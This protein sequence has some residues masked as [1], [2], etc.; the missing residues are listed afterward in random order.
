MANKGNT[1]FEV[2]N[3]EGIGWVE[4]PA[5]PGFWIWDKTAV[6]EAP[7]DGKQYC[8]QNADWTEAVTQSHNHEIGD[9]DG[10]EDQLNDIKLEVDQ[11]SGQLVFGGT[12]DATNDQVVRGL[13]PGLS[14]LTPLPSDGVIEDTFLIVVVPGTWKKDGSQLN[15]GDW[16]VANRDG[17]WDCIQYTSTG[18]GTAVADWNTITNKPDFDAIYAQLVHSHVISDV[19][20][21][22]AELDG[23]AA[24]IV[25]K[26][27]GFY[28]NTAFNKNF[29]TTAGTVAEGDHNHDADYLQVETD[30]VFTASVAGGITQTDIDNWN[31]GGTAAGADN[32]QYWRYQ[33]DGTS[34]TNIMTMHTVNF[35][36][37]DNM[38]ISKDG[39]G[40]IVFKSTAT[41][42]GSGTDSRITDT[43][44]S[45]WDSAFN[46]GDHS[47][48]GY[49]D[50]S[51]L[52]NYATT[53]WVTSSFQPLGSYITSETD[54]VFTASPAYGITSK[55]ITDWD[56]AAAG[57]G[58]GSGSD[59][60]RISNTDI[61][62]WHEAYGWGDHSTYS[63]AT[64]TW[65]NNKN[66]ATQTWVN[67]KSYATQ[68]WVTSQ[69]YA[70]QSWVTT[71]GYLT[72]GSLTGYATQT[73][74]NNQGFA[75]GSFVPTS[76]NSTISG[77]L[78]ATDFVAS[79]DERLKKNVCTA[80]TGVLE[81]IR[82]V[83][84]EWKESGQ[85][86]SGVIAQELEAVPELAHLVHTGED[87]GTKHVSYLG[88]IGYLIE[89]VKSLR[90][91]IEELK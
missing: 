43:Q 11:L 54:P 78:T 90:A 70:T 49:L 7:E 12:Y 82:G 3:P 79:S 72:S 40:A 38:D 69:S 48:Q 37:G 59:D 33:I 58:G 22:Q 25:A 35:K 71:Q 19:T 32:Y 6:E 68:S 86:S 91:E 83:E 13:A 8:R 52:T 34:T 80:P 88:L 28:K 44:I 10:L 4:D 60:T 87:D 66:Y 18:G 41:G 45:N 1:P 15:E 46:W 75:K 67:N 74:V 20:G 65:V 26:E 24:D 50:S 62:N 9:V 51:D 14:N 47:T 56:A 73:W 64:E 61:A 23:L 55:Q 27:D 2:P 76:G 77:V 21:L 63:Y 89:E 36:A 85:M 84:F 30:P 39:S 29:G 31:A 53:A 17:V 16:I 57:G 5:R 81:K 42:G